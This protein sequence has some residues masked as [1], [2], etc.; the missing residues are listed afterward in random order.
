MINKLPDRYYCGLSGLQLPTPRYLYPE[1]YQKS[2]RLTYYSTFFNSIELNSIFY[3]LPREI[4][5]KKWADQV[6]TDFRLT[7]KL[8]K[9]ITHVKDLNF[10]SSDISD[11]LRTITA[12][13]E[14]KGCI[15]IQFPPRLTTTNV[16]QLQNLLYVIRSDERT[17]GW[18]LAVEFR[19]GAW[20][21][22]D[23]FDLLDEYGVSL[24]I[25]D[26]P[27]SATPSI[28]QAVD[29]IYVRFHGPTGN[30]RGSYSSD[31]LR[32]YAGYIREW[33]MAYKTVYVY[34]NNTAGDAFNNL[35]TLN[36]FLIDR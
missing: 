5:V 2:S 24:V 12:V 32:E 1:A 28:E 31:Y 20:Y 21:Y 36:S 25:Q 15:L 11:F 6:S 22:P 29:V 18:R 8:S 17:A 16:H 27:K 35:A 3:K 19:N 13:G 14:K 7:F 30:Y 4:T 10:K 33:L 26:M 9:D 34:F 23:V